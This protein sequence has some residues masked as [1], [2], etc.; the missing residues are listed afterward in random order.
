MFSIFSSLGANMGDACLKL[1]T[2]EEINTIDSLK[3]SIDKILEQIGFNKD[4]IEM[5]KLLKE[6]APL[7]D[8][9]EI[10]RLA[11]KNASGYYR[12]IR[13]N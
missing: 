7:Q 10:K 3:A 1:P 8:E 13:Y 6:T 4:F 5:K 9:L 11:V 2:Y 12:N